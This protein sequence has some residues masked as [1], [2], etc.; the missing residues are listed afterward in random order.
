MVLVFPH[1]VTIYNRDKEEHYHRTVITGVLW[2][3]SKGAVVR[4]TGVSSV[5]GLQ[6]IIPMSAQG[7]LK[8]SDWLELA[9]KTV[10]WTLQPRDVVVLGKIEYEVVKSIKELQQFDDMLTISNIDTKKF[11]SNL[12]HWEVSGK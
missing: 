12:D 1:T 10:H 9:N 5:D 7:Y 3:S 4:K 8:P 11:G 6:L 2:D